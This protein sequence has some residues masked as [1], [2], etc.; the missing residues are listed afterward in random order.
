MALDGGSTST[1]MPDVLLDELDAQIADLDGLEGPARVDAILDHIDEMRTREPELQLELV[2]HAHMLA[3]E[4]G[5]DRGVAH[6]KGHTGR[7]LYLLSRHHEA[8]PLL[9]EAIDFFGQAAEKEAATLYR[10]MLAAL[11]SS[12]GNYEEAMT[13]ALENLEDA[14]ALGDNEAVAWVLTGL[15]GGYLELGAPD[16]ALSYAMESLSTFTTL[17]HVTGQA[18]AHSGVGTVLRTMGRY[19]EAEGHHEISLQLFQEGDD[20]LGESRAYHDLGLVAFIRDDFELALEFHDKALELRRRIKNRQAESTTLIE[21]GRT[22]V[23][24]GR[25][26]EAFESLHAARE[27]AEELE[28]RPKLFEVHLVLAAACEA[29]GDPA[30]ALE[31]YRRYHEIHEEVLGSQVTG[32]VQSLQ[33]CHEAERAQQEA[34]IERLQNVELREKNEQL[35]NLLAEL[36]KTQNRLV[37]SEKLASLGRVTSGIAHE[38]K[39]PLNFVVNFAELNGEL[40]TDMEGVLEERRSDLPEDVIAMFSDDFET[41][42]ENIARVIENARRADGIVKSM[43]GHLR[44]TG[45]SRRP[46]DIHELLKQAAVATFGDTDGGE[47]ITIHW[48]SDPKIEAI[49]MTAQSMQR[50]FVNVL[51]NA[52]YSMFGRAKL[53]ENGFEPTIEI[54]TKRLPGMVQVRITDNGFGIPAENCTRI[55]EPFFTTKPTG[56]GTGLGLSLAYDIVT[57]GHG[58]SMAAISKEGE[59]ATLVVTLPE[60]EG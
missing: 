18:R 24:L 12:Q 52:R 14:R 33:V 2:E 27:I 58:G 60:G 46:T 6:S 29:A 47:G 40:I 54:K 31:H 53:E 41:I 15:S 25:G 39:N 55:F 32:R 10:G 56:E 8:V 49:E 3:T 35:E 1:P 37:Q 23:R 48:D 26:E 11:Y 19:E 44:H 17:G 45:G 50:V 34:E 38:I 7:A 43:L 36:K 13:L 21:R 5:Y 16:V 22:L 20:Q 4:L 57:Q 51:D 9:L 59:G 28:L 30:K 42:S